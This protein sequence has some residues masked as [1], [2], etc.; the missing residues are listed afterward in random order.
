MRVAIFHDY[1][2]KMG[3]GERLVINLARKLNADIYTGFIDKENTFNTE[4][5]KITS[6]EVSGRPRIYRNIKIARKFSTLR[7]TGYDFYIFSGVWCI[8]AAKNHH[9]NILY[10]HTPLRALYDLKGYYMKNSSLQRIALTGFEKYWKP[11]DRKYMNEFDVV[12]ANSE[13]VKRRVLKYYG[14]DLYDRTRVV[15]TGIETSKFKFVKEGDFYLSA[16]RLDPLK[17]IDILIRVFLQM[18]DRKLLITGTGPDEKRLRRL[19]EGARNIHFLGNVSDEKLRMLYSTCKA[20]IAANVNEDLGLIAIESHA[21]GKPII[22]IKEGG[23]LETVN[24]ENGI[25]FSGEDDLKQAIEELENRKWN[26]DKIRKSAERFDIKTFTKNIMSII[27]EVHARRRSPSSSE[28][29]GA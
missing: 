16:S 14:K 15:Y 11:R 3:G 26:H 22:A 8:S 28:Y 17:R 9:P 6:L 2:D 27:E 4:G 24:S 5:I 20:T 7:L 1:F 25:F 23:F 21:S 18:P 19:A 13:N 12:C 10:L 29:S